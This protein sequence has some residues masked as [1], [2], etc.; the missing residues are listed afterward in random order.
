MVARQTEFQMYK[1]REYPLDSTSEKE[2][3]IIGSAG[4]RKTSAEVSY[5]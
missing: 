3:D 4:G 1:R 5:F 2:T